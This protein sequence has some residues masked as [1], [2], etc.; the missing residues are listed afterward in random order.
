MV[1]AQLGQELTSTVV[2]QV[3]GGKSGGKGLNGK[4]LYKPHERGVAVWSTVGASG[5]K[6]KS[7]LRYISNT[8]TRAFP[9]RPRE[10]PRLTL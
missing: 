10:K 7:A 8:V 9:V 3:M 1:L 4:P 6:Q 2:D 5:C